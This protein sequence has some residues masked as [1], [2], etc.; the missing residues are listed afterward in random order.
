M[1]GVASGENGVRRETQV[2]DARIVRT[3]K[4]WGHFEQYAHNLPC[5]VKVI[6]VDP[7]G[8]L[9]RQYHHHRD[10]LWVVLDAG[11]EIELGDETLRPE[12]A[13]KLFI[14]RGTA[15]RL[16][17]VG[18]EPARILEVSFGDFDEDDI[19]RLDDA[20]GRLGPAQHGK[21]EALEGWMVVDGRLRRIVGL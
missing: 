4:P 1:S 15:H 17:C 19:V 9:S 13:E 3:D 14:P 18:D 16:S 6:T 10:E 11:A 5:T 7:N 2:E 20:Y 21:E 8:T 12:P